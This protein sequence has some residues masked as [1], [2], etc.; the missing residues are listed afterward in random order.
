MKEGLRMIK[1]IGVVGTGTI[2]HEFMTQLNRERYEVVAVFNLNPVSLEKFSKEYSIPNAFTKYDEFLIADIDLVYIASPNQTH[3]SY[4]KQALEAGKHCLC[5]KVMV[6][7]GKESQEL[8]ALAES[9]GLV[10]LEAVSLFYMPL[11]QELHVCLSQ[12]KLG[13][14][15]VVNVTFGSCKEYDE[16][17]RFFSPAKG[18]GALFDIGTYALSAAL[19]FMGDTTQ[20]RA[21]NV[22]MAPSDVDEKSVTLLEN[23][24]QVLGSVMISFRGKLP[25]QIFVSGDLG[26][27][28]VEDFPRATSAK[29]Y[30][31]NGEIEQIS[32][33]EAEDVFTYE[34]DMVN[35]YLSESS[36]LPDLRE[37]TQRVI[38][39]MDDMREE[40]Q[41][42]ID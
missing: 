15:S 38:S 32:S 19:Y 13:K 29:I 25:K 33:G 16:A 2:A 42:R 21:S 28:V 40:W 12:N 27:L 18:G 39:I 1:K 3:Y 37:L 22:V 9:K 35:R 7:K 30:Y 36:P 41:W 17:N 4:V 23:D 8:F 24:D 31:N 10:L 5:E 11:Y 20:L 6:L 34:L 26:Y 14:L